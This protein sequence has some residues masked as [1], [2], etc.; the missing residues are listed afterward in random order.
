[1]KPKYGILIFILAIFSTCSSCKKSTFLDTKPD[2]SL[3]VP[4]TLAD[5]QAI[6]DNDLWMNGA[7]GD[8]IV[9]SLGEVGADNYYLLDANY[10]ALLTPF[11]KNEYIWAKSPYPGK[12]IQDWDFPYRAV[13]YSNSTIEGLKHI[14][15]TNDNRLAW[16][17]VQ[18]SAFFF[19]AFNFYQLAQVFSPPFD[20]STYKTDWGIPLRLSSDINEKLQRATV[21][22]TYD[23]IISDLKISIQ[24]LPVTPLYGTRPSKAAAYA[25]LSRVFQTIGDYNNALLY[26]DSSLQLRNKLMDFNTLPSASTSPI[27]TF[28]IESLFCCAQIFSNAFSGNTDTTLYNSYDA[29][30]LRKVIFFRLK[31]G[32]YRFK[33]SYGGGLYY[34]GGIAT[35]EVYLIRAEC[36]ARKGNVTSALND[37]NTLLN[38]RWKSGTFVPFAASNASDALSL[39]LRE[40]RKELLMRGLRW[41]DLRRLNKDPQFSITLKRIVHG[42]SYSLSPNNTRYTYPIPD[43]V[44]SFNPGMPQNN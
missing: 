22:Q 33:G 2:Q 17:N 42:Q 43:D 13:F 5:L 26:S 30:D 32:A 38:A 14:P 10:D 31:N 11:E 40:R 29:N 37:L 35:D 44:I 1:M 27:P 23:Q 28:N 18:G 25:L 3:V 9:P 16:N 12:G 39:I 4:S 19:R 41:I 15:S 34:F 36:Y 20:S 21:Q 8:G 6:L 7:Q 24:F